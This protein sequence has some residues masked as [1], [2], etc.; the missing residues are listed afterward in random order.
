[1]FFDLH[2]KNPYRLDVFSASIRDGRGNILTK[3]LFVVQTSVDAQL[4][5]RQPTI[6]LD[7]IA[8]EALTSVPSDGGL[9]TRSDVEMCLLRD[10]LQP[11]LEESRKEREREIHVISRHIEIS[12]GEII[13]RENLMLADLVSQKESGSTESGLDGRI[14]ISEDKLIELD[15]RLQ[16]RRSELGR[17]RQ[18][19]IGDIHHIGRAWVL[20]H[21]DRNL[22]KIASMVSDP[23]IER[24]A[25]EVVKTIFAMLIASCSLKRWVQVAA[26]TC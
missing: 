4:S 26:S 6:F 20:L 14:K 11:M 1:V 19:S 21:P 17:E 12:L 13:N 2:S 15:H 18:C 25:V 24:I 10:A 5:V 8:S 22:P 9:P 16:S 23:E 3:R 7:L